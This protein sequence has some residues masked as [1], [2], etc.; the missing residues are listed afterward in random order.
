MSAIYNHYTVIGSKIT[1]KVSPA[2]VSN[3][4]GAV[5]IMLNDDTNASALTNISAVCEQT[6]GK[7]LKLIPAGANNVYK[8]THKWSAKKTFGG[9]ILG[10]D[11][12]QG[13]ISANPVEQ[14][15][16]QVFYQ[17]LGVATSSVNIICEVE[18][19]A[20]W[21]ELKEVAQS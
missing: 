2:S 12:L 7:M 19:I 21:D 1:V 4:P 16:F 13:S 9:S 10:N 20:V 18:Y 5:G 3:G 11:N 6:Q 17:D 8:L 14:T 15:H